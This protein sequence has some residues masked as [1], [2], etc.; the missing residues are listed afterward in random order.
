MDGA[1][2]T[3]VVADVATPKRKRA[4]RRSSST[5]EQS[6][7]REDGPGST[8]EPER[9]PMDS[10]PKT[11]P[12]ADVVAT[13]PN[14]PSPGANGAAT[15]ID[16]WLMV[17]PAAGMADYVL[18]PPGNYPGT[19][20]SVIDIGHQPNKFAKDG[21]TEEVHQLVLVF[22]LAERQPDGKPFLLSRSFT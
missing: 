11:E 9:T 4:P 6:P 17:V 2:K 20:S 3:D 12:I 16:P 7:V 15:V 18:C 1:P 13:P 8:T 10:A 21:S 14:R 5:A 19:I 22:E